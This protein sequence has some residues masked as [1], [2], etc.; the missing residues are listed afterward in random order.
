MSVGVATLRQDLTTF[1]LS[2]TLVNR[3]PED[4]LNVAECVHCVH[5]VAGDW[6]GK[7]GRKD[8]GSIKALSFRGSIL[9]ERLVLCLSNYVTTLGQESSY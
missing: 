9:L 8:K 7:G 5:P 3:E 2:A 4:C 6:E 1:P